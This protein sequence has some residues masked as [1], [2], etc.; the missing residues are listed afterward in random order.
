[1]R[2]ELLGPVR[3]GDGRDGWRELRG[4]MPRTVLAVL[5]LDAGRVVAAEDLI[6]IVWGGRE[7]VSAPDSLNNHVM[8]LRR[9]LGDEGG[10]RIRSVAHGFQLL[11]EPG[12]CDVHEFDGLRAAGADSLRDGDWARAAEQLSAALA[13]WRGQPAADCP[14]VAGLARVREL[15]DARLGALEGRIAADL[16][17]GR[18]REVIGELRALTAEQPRHEAFHAHLMLALYRADRQAEALDVFQSLRR[19]SV[20]GPGTEPS[21]QV[22]D[23]HGRILA[24]DPALAAPDGAAVPPAAPSRPGAAGIPGATGSA[25]RPGRAGES[26]E[27]GSPYQLPSDV[28]GFIGR[29]RELDELLDL[30][31]A[32]PEGTEAG[33]VLISAIDGM[34]GIGKTALAVAAAH[35]LRGRFPDGQLFLDLR[36]HSADRA[37]LTAAD[38]LDW[39]LR[40]LGMPPQA[41][42]LDLGERAAA[43]R[44]R[45]AGTRTLIILD[46]AASAAQVRP[47]LPDTPGCLV[48]VTGR[49]RLA[50]LDDAHA[51][52]LDVLPD[53]DAAALLH[54]IAGPGRIP[55]HH[56]AVGELTA[57]CGR[58]PLAVRITAAHLRHHPDLR[59]EDLV[60][61]L[62]DE[63]ARLGRLDLLDGP[64]RDLTAVFES[65]YASLPE[66]ERHLFRQLGLVP[67]SDFDAH[68]AANLVG[69]DRRTAEHLLES[70]LAH[71]LL[72][73]HTPGRYRFHDLV[74]VYARTL[75]ASGPAEQSRAALDRLLD[76][77]QHTADT[78][79]R[80]L[81]RLPRP[82]SSTVLTSPD[83]VFGLPDR[84]T[85]LTWMRAEDE[86]L[87]AALA[88]AAAR[89]Q[90]DRV[91]GLTTALAAF[92]QLEGRW[93]LGATL[94]LAAA[95]T[96]RECGPGPGGPAAEA[97]AL[98]DLGRTR[99]ATG[100][101]A[102]ALGLFERG[103][104]IYQ[105][106]G[107]QAGQA[108]AEFELSRVRSITGD[109]AAGLAMV[110]HALGLYQELGDRLGQGSAMQELGRIEGVTGLFTTAA[111]RYQRAAEIFQE[112]GHRHG[113][114]GALWDLGRT[115]RAMGDLPAAVELLERSLV[116]YRE[117]GIRL[118]EA[119][120]LQDLGEVHNMSG[121][122]PAAAELNEQA[123]VIYRELGAR[124]GEAGALQ[125]LGRIR[126]V[127]GDYR[128]ADAFHRDA[129][130]I[131]RDLGAR[132]GEGN[133][134]QD[135]GRVALELGDLAAA[136][137]L[138]EESL[139][140]FR[141]LG[142]RHG[143][144][145]V[146]GDLGRVRHRTGDHAAAA[147]L[148]GQAVAIFQEYSDPQGEAEAL[149]GLAAL[150]T[151]TE[152]PQQALALYRRAQG[153]ARE[154][155]SAI[156]ESRA[157]E[158]SARCLAAAGDRDAA[159]ADLAEAVAIYQRLGAAE[160]A[161]AAAW[162]DELRRGRRTSP[163]VLGRPGLRL[164]PRTPR[165]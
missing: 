142:T 41:V 63:I 29:T 102:A 98:L 101:H 157:L 160:A 151:D 124:H 132:H 8:R 43:Y 83:P 139:A 113:E 117:L 4:T 119:N 120:S 34:G 111:E 146:L 10:A 145:Y 22:Q 94:H 153:L 40:S 72:A 88:D 150:V 14:A 44:D 3:V 70:L 27:N 96:A 60:G 26:A 32:A 48:L 46:D 42:P 24:A 2:F 138:F 9:M 106:L 35:R 39:F 140:I 5:L 89:K 13:L 129:L 80:Y 130:V 143:E 76:Y 16:E 156:D 164:P 121:D 54:Q 123:L 75:S 99:L 6:E 163:A 134:V 100:D 19:A 158:G 165:G 77:Y 57:L 37:P 115:R 47:L 31:A 58:M 78:A 11:V 55:A 131:Y 64:E 128:A 21:A 7:P 92:L 81:A 137:E 159:V 56:P 62:R 147:D 112:I 71:N 61:R 79:D 90:P 65:S 74:R 152:G 1:M 154:S 93:Q 49:R 66:A 127:A 59:I 116:A 161:A 73:Q 148:L 95:D 53:R 25:G 149:V 33:M 12:E 126:H 103:H 155:H 105:G 20:D 133:A 84:A 18:H 135:L 114:A 69:T 97:N 23:L 136:A 91:I 125:D 68:A 87:L 38:A 162:L 82:G 107:D 67:G 45:L 15:L 51:L 17:L 28:R 122:Y 109:L 50:G 141:D 52:A 108:N 104:E 36:G 118:G 85:A 30:A 86:N 110:T 144:A